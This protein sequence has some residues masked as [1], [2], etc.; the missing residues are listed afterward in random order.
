M[1]LIVIFVKLIYKDF[2][3]K[4]WKIVYP[5][6]QSSLKPVPHGID[7]PISKAP[8]PEVFKR[9]ESSSEPDSSSEA[10]ASD[11]E[12]LAAIS[13]IPVFINQE[14]VERSGIDKIQS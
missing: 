8:S 11:L 1:L 4:K 6:C 12:L 3:K 7:I 13:N 2:L 14:H 5:S 9:P 10:T